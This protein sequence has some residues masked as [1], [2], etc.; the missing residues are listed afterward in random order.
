MLVELIAFAICLHRKKR[1]IHTFTAAF[2][3]E[4]KPE[5]YLS[6][7]SMFFPVLFHLKCDTR[8]DVE[9]FLT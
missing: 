4:R 2:S 1:M 8:L 5:A 6:N 3:M 9:S 7:Y